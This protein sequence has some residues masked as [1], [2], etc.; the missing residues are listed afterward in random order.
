MYFLSLLLVFINGLKLCCAVV[1]AGLVKKPQ[2]IEV[3]EGVQFYWCHNK[4]DQVA[5]WCPCCVKPVRAGCHNTV[6]NL[7]DHFATK[8][9]KLAYSIWR[10][11]FSIYLIHSP[12][13]QLIY[14]FLQ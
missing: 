13:S 14:A 11:V 8:C 4:Y 3:V 9:H 12:R 6:S 7:K 1:F 10:K 2:V 5:L